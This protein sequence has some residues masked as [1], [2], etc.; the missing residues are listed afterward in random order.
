ME[1]DFKKFSDRALLDYEENLYEREKSGEATWAERD[2]VIVELNRR[3]LL[4]RRDRE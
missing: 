1:N 3:R 2:Q 4:S